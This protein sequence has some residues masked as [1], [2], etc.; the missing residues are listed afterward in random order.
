M[1]VVVSAYACEPGRGSEPGVGWAW[2]ELISEFAQVTVLTRANNRAAIEAAAAEHEWVRDVTWV[3]HDLSE[4]A[5]ALKRRTGFTQAYYAAWQRSAKRVVARILAEQPADLVHHLTFGTYWMPYATE[6]ADVPVL[7]G[8]VGGA[9]MPPWSFVA[10]D[11]AAL[12]FEFFRALAR[13]L[14]EARPS[15]RR[16]IR[17]AALCVAKARESAERLKDLGAREVVVRS[18]VV[19]PASMLSTRVDRTAHDVLELV[20]LSRLVQLKGLQLGLRALAGVRDQL[21]PFHYTLVGDGPHRPKLERLVGELS[22][23]DV[24]T[25]VGEKPRSEALRYLERADLFLLPSLHDSGG[26]ACVEAMWSGLPVVCLDIGGPAS[27]VT[28]ETGRAVPLTTPAETVAALGQAILELGSDDEKRARASEAARLRV[29]REYSRE[30][31]RDWLRGV[32]EDIV[33]GAGT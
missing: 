23:G 5:L 29:E 20:S 1:R 27:Q 33:G 17:G 16:A 26:W 30:S 31:Q 19:M 13:S 25:F 8:P 18:E 10:D 3:Y 15:V 11:F 9:E 4:T 22:L 6:S 32:Y 28:P 24:V 2:V 14:S 7:I 12:R 21:P